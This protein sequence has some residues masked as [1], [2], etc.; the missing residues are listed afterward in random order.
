[1]ASHL[2][3]GLDPF[4]Y[5]RAYTGFII[6]KEFALTYAPAIYFPW[7]SVGSFDSHDI[8]FDFPFILEQYMGASYM[9][10]N[11]YQISLRTTVFVGENF[12]GKHWRVNTGIDYLF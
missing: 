2:G 8:T 4:P 11:K 6:T 3:T 10:K 9:L 1:M 12:A 7:W 5:F